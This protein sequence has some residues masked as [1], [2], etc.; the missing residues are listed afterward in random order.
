MLAIT[1]SSCYCAYES[2][3]RAWVV[4]KKLTLLLILVFN[5][6]I[7]VSAT[8]PIA[9][10]AEHERVELT[11]SLEFSYT[12]T[13]ALDTPPVEGWSRYPHN[14]ILLDNST[15]TS[16]FRVHLKNESIHPRAFYLEFDNPL[17]D[18]LSVYVL[19]QGSVV[20]SQQVGDLQKFSHR[21]VVHESFV[22][23]IQFEA[24]Q[25]LEVYFA[26]HSP[27]YLRIPVTLWQVTAFQK[28]QS[29]ER[30]ISGL[31]IGMITALV[32][33]TL[34]GF[35]FT[36]NTQLLLDSLFITALFLI[37]LTA[38][39]VGF[40]YLWPNSPGIQQHAFY[41]FSCI[42]MFI[43]ALAA[44]MNVQTFFFDDRLIKLFTG[45][46]GLSVALIP[47]TLLVSYQ[48]GLLLIIGLAVAMSIAHIAIGLYTWQSGMREHQELNYGII[49]LLAAL[50]LISANSFGL[51]ELPITNLALLQTSVLIQISL[52]VIFAI[53]DNTLTQP[54]FGN[55]LNNDEDKDLQ[56]S[57]QMLELQL[58]LKELQ[59][60]NELLEKLNTL[61]ELSG[62]HNRRHFDKRLQAE[63]RRGRRELSPLSLIMFDIDHFKRFNDTYG[64]IAGDEVIRAVALTASQQLNRDSDEIFRY[65]GEEYAILLPN[66]ELEGASFIAEK[67]R[68]A[69]ESLVIGS[70]E[71]SL[72][73]TIS[74]GVAC[75]LSEQ[76]L[77]PKDFIEQADQALYQA[78]QNGRNQV[79]LHNQSR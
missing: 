20:S 6:F 73:C 58:A 19:S 15:G 74:L 44:R 25:A 50:L 24:N 2:I 45:L 61:D 76:A 17:I 78:K 26:I 68:S 10:S 7:Q 55:S 43:S 71:K 52:I 72:N 70:D 29:N 40:H 37:T 49:V 42:A 16:W 36:R 60:K 30:L 63:L 41:L 18:E 66:T 56:L 28:A 9:F 65:G 51:I 54:E 22:V 47:L 67:V 46:A 3:N 64:H 27:S 13:R 35:V 39:G 38:S 12:P 48:V 4:V 21:S 57:E 77:Q 31:Y 34:V 1:E 62:I 32:I 59:E 53:K 75:H 14:N 79:A 33:A 23:P 69:I 5:L 8:Q 11:Q